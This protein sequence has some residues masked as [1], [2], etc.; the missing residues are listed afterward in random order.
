MALTKT[1]ATAASVTTLMPALGAREVKARID[2]VNFSHIIGRLTKLY[3]NPVFATVR[4]TVSNATDATQSLPEDQRKPVEITSPNP[5]QKLFTVR[6]HGIGMSIDDVDKNFANY[7]STT[8]SS[9]IKAIGS[10]GLGGKSPLAYTT[11]FDV[12]TTKDGVTTKFTMS[13]SSGEVMT[14]IHSVEQTGLPSGTEV[15]I[16]TESYDTDRFS[17]AISFYKEHTHNGSVI[18]DGV[19][20]TG[21][22]GYYNAGSVVLYEDSDGPLSGNIY[23]DKLTLG[24]YFQEYT[25]Y[26]FDSGSI[27]YS[28][29]G[30]LYSAS[31]T[32]HVDHRPMVVVELVPALVNFGSSRDAITDDEKL[33]EANQ[34]VNKALASDA[35]V[36]T[37][38]AEYR[39]LER[40]ELARFLRLHQSRFT[41]S[42]D[43]QNFL[44]RGNYRTYSGSIELLKSELGFNPFLIDTLAV[45][46]S[47]TLSLSR[48]NQ[49]SITYAFNDKSPK[50]AR[51]VYSKTTAKTGEPVTNFERAIVGGE[52]AITDYAKKFMG[53]PMPLV[54]VTS[55]TLAD[56]KKL[57]RQ[58]AALFAGGR[59]EMVFMVSKLAKPDATELET[60][61]LVSGDAITVLS[62]TE[63][64][65]LIK[66][67]IDQKLKERK[68][69]REDR[70]SKVLVDARYIRAPYSPDYSDVTAVSKL[71][72]VRSPLNSFQAALDS[73][74]IL[75]FANYWQHVY[76]GALNAGVDLKDVPVAI[77]DQKLTATEA[78]KLLPYK[79]R[80]Y[81]SPSTDL[82]TAAAK[83]LA[84]GRVFNGSVLNSVLA[85]F[86]REQLI[87]GVSN[88]MLHGYDFKALRLMEDY[89]DKSDKPFLAVFRAYIAGEKHRV[90]IESS[91]A[92]KEL[93]D[94][95]GVKYLEAVRELQAGVHR[96]FFGTSIE[97]QMAKLL[98]SNPRKE[99]IELT[100]VT[101]AVL[102]FAAS[103][104]Q[105]KPEATAS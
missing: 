70:D 68:R 35:F 57:I 31:G 67:D 99:T 42:D 101:E 28:L 75:I 65:E 81:F 48:G 21:N 80:L 104:L 77:Y 10:H 93:T 58:R 20:Y 8:K 32:S 45:K 6:D 83:E 56:M 26:G 44:L 64:F 37:A 100:P 47:V 90:T 73:G 19:L 3:N 54:L 98:V 94:R 89:L 59:S 40:K 11:S 34:R 102:K 96:A 36:E 24:Q 74:A 82:P 29:F 72:A 2:E 4:E 27:S 1:D 39:K 50:Y 41:V 55:V 38:L 18:V 91:D 60:A 30:W 51:N 5:L 71:S 79:D 62:A 25:G 7:G 105:R 9:D 88:Y 103:E 85:S 86:T 17:E 52:L 66:P 15:R 22:E 92:A 76:I 43:K 69:E 46:P 13:R 84:A 16:P 95:F 78:A 49:E 23:I 12:T 63:L 33:A 14:T 87:V 53:E 97:H 61:N